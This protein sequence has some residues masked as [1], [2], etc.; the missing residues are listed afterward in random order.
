MDNEGRGDGGDDSQRNPPRLGSTADI[1]SRL[2]KDGELTEGEAE[3]VTNLLQSLK[4][5]VN[6]YRHFNRADDSP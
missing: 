6:R 3:C 2:L 1:V 5:K 4:V